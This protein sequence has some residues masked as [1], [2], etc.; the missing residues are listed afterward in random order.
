[1]K[2]L[3]SLF[4]ITSLLFN[5][6]TAQT[7]IRNVNVLDVENQKILSGY[8]V[9]SMNGKITYVGKDKKFKLPATINVIDGTGKYLI[10]G[11]TDAH[12]HFFQ[13]GGI[14]TRPDAIDLTKYKSLD[15]ELKWAHAHMKDFLSLYLKAGITQV[16]D[17][18]ATAEF[19]AQRDSFTTKTTSPLIYMTGPLLTTYVPEEY[20]NAQ[21]D[22]TFS[23]MTNEADTRK[24]VTDQLKYKPDFIKIWYIV[25]DSN[26]ERGA[27]INQQ[28]V[29]IAIDESHKHN[30]PVAV[31][32]TER[33]TAQLAVE[34]GADYLVHSVDDELLTDS[35]VQLL[36]SH[37]V[38]LC[39]TL[40]VGTNYGKV[41]SGDY[42]FTD[43]EIRLSDPEQ[44]ATI[45]AFPQPDTALGNIFINNI[46]KGK[47]FARRKTADSISGVNLKKLVDAGVTVA[48]GTDA[49][50]IGTQ[51]AGSYYNELQAMADAGLTMWQ[52]L[53]ASTINGAKA[54]GKEKEWGSISEGKVAN[55]LLLDGNPLQGLENWK[56]INKVINKG[57]VSRQRAQ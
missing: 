33:I 8:D 53:T 50:N 22:V 14:Y 6:A 31:H 40:V 43:D 25:L 27:R 32:A 29:K 42:K 12:V 17:V 7:Y 9:L 24:G 54:I 3:I 2:Y 38:V 20:R 5:K 51:H 4:L 23:L 1:M 41:L 13:T 16:I 10:P 37:N 19:L 44:V 46:K 55:M 28:L 47:Y 52:L 21:H 39:P 34:A 26:V 57:L 18:G 15:E 30:L 11:Y 45:K 35:F 49:G 36:K 48:S 56:K